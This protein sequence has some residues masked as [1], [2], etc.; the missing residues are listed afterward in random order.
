MDF[1][2]A[3]IKGIANVTK[4]GTTLGTTTYMSPEQAKG[5]RVDHR[6]DIWSFGVILYEMITG[7][8]PFKGDYEQA[9]IYSIFNEEPEPLTAI[10]TGVPKELE[11]IISKALA[12]NPAERYQHADELLVDLKAIAKQ[13]DP[14]FTKSHSSSS[15]ALPPAKN[16]SHRG[17][18]FGIA[19]VSAII[20]C[21]I[22]LYLV[23]PSGESTGDRKS[24]AVL[25]FKNLSEDKS[26]EF[27]S[28]GITEDIIAQLSKISDLRVIS[29]TSVMR[30]KNSS[31]S[32]REIGKE[33][34]VA[35]IL[36]GSVRRADNQIRIVAQLIDANTDEHL[37]AETYDKELTQIFAI[38]S[39]VA[40]QIGT[41]LKA[42]L[43]PEEKERIE[44][45]HTENLEAYTYYLRG[46]EHYSRYQRQDNE[47][48]IELFKKALEIDPNYALAYAG[49]GDSYGQRTNKFGFSDDWI[50]SAIA[51]SSKAI[52]L[53]PSLAEG[54]KALGLAYQ[55]KGWNKRALEQN[56]KAISLNPNYDPAVGN[57]GWINLFLG[58]LDEALI[59]KKKSLRLNPAVAFQYF[60][61][62]FAYLHLDNFEKA[63][64]NFNKALEI[65][66]G[67]PAANFGLSLLYITWGKYDKAIELSEKLIAVFPEELSY[68][69]L[70]PESRYFASKLYL[71][72]IYWKA[73]EMA[74]AERMFSEVLEKER[75]RISNGDERWETRYNITAINAIR[76]DTQEAFKWLQ[77]S[78]DAGFRLYRLA[79]KDPT[80]EHLHNDPQFRKMMA[81]VKKMVY[82]MQT[83][84]GKMEAL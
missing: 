17:V 64:E 35:T 38:Q 9:V 54:Y 14:D 56:Q 10:R 45:P 59:W 29:R 82:E 58:N 36:E 84:V 18:L 55:E 6:S 47:K 61:L 62:G 52:A 63:E 83:R 77:N 79:Q 76:G 73:G 11:R 48:A 7:Q 69:A 22:A 46:R 25:P 51:T 34:N 70:Y 65:Q 2:L 8:L 72:Y 67:L 30:Y 19:G 41:A 43:S 24:V 20:I 66:P 3:K 49:L 80:L 4:E 39:D 12:K 26:N 1:G 74:F 50:D 21:V 75:K 32:L 23:W 44:K 16:K 57:M 81:D 28:D 71:G 15:A 68:L 37:W 40:Q 5:E 42:E 13:L 78:I 60:G 27:F 33:L 53:D 31:K